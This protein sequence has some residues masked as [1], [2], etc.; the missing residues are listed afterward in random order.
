MMTRLQKYFAAGISLVFFTGIFL[1]FRVRFS[2]NLGA[3]LIVA[4]GL[5]LFQFLLWLPTRHRNLISYSVAFIP[6]G[7][8]A[9]VFATGGVFTTAFPPSSAMSSSG[10]FSNAPVGLSK[11]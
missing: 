1:Y 11:A 4:A 10:G 6:A 5:T 8:F 2:H 3:A 9:A 7:I